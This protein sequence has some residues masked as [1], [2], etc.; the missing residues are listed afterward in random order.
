MGKQYESYDVCRQRNDYR[1]PAGEFC[2]RLPRPTGVDSI[3]D[4]LTRPAN[5]NQFAYMLLSVHPDKMQKL[6]DEHDRVCGPSVSEAVELLQDRPHLT[7]ELEYTTAVL[8]EALRLYPI[9]FTLRTDDKW[10]V[11]SPS[12]SPPPYLMHPLSL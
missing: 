6:R 4:S 7:A 10:Y 2:F 9:G 5:K 11:V 3:P 1:Y 12:F 8:K